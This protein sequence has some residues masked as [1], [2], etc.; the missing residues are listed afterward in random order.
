MTLEEKAK[1]ANES[2]Y[3]A[4]N[5]QNLEKMREVWSNLGQ[6]SCVHPGWPPLNNYES[7][8]KSW[9]DIFENT[10]NMEIKLSEIEAL[11]TDDLAWVRCQENLF[12]ISMTGVQASKVFATNLFQRIG[13]DWKMVL[14][15]ASHLPQV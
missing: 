13:E 15:H 12:S 1:L 4:F 5:S 3:K 2:F 8:I 9:K 7:I 14:H 10:D 11:V 6:V